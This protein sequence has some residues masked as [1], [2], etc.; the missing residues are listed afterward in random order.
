MKAL[1]GIVI[2]STAAIYAHEI[3]QDLIAD[4]K[5]N[6]YDQQQIQANQPYNQSPS[7]V[8][9]RQGSYF[10]YPPDRGPSYNNNYYYYQQPSNSQY[11]GYPQ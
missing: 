8:M 4:N 6:L 7:D 10:Y 1:L 2:L 11:Y 9:S 3:P 5:P